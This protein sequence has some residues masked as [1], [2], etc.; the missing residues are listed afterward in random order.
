ADAGLPAGRI[1][2]TGV[3]IDAGRG[4]GLWVRYAGRETMFAA[5]LNAETQHVE[6]GTLTWYKDGSSLK[7][8]VE[9]QVSFPV[10][11]GVTHQVRILLRYRYAE[12]Y[13]DDQLARSFVCQA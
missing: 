5:S 6:L 12:L 1:I 8:D 7:F 9:E 3:R 4:L 2:E 11:A 10:T 13:V